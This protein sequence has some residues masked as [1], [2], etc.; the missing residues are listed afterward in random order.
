MVVDWNGDAGALHGRGK[1]G[2]LGEL[3]D[4]EVAFLEPEL[5][6]VEGLQVDGGEMRAAADRPTSYRGQ[7]KAPLPERVT[8]H[9][10]RRAWPTGGMHPSANPGR[11]WCQFITLTTVTDLV[12]LNMQTCARSTQGRLIA[13]STL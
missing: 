4:V 9:G 12:T 1:L 13:G 10:H 5:G 6:T 3:G 2:K 8:S 7:V 11:Y